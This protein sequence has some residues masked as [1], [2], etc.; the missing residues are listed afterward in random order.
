MPTNTGTTSS[1]PW[2]VLRRRQKEKGKFTANSRHP[3]LPHTFTKLT[4]I[5]RT[6]DFYLCSAVPIR[7]KPSKTK[8]SSQFQT[9]H[10]LVKRSRVRLCGQQL[11]E[12]IKLVCRQAEA[13]G[14]R[15]RRRRR[16]EADPAAY[17]QLQVR[18]CFRIWDMHA[19]LEREGMGLWILPPWFPLG[20]CI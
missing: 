2:S 12:M 4:T 17:F 19:P 3:C 16:R 13:M 7:M 6:S 8:K 5:H 11:V 10:S 14:R 18:K 9:H 15:G 20:M 1:V